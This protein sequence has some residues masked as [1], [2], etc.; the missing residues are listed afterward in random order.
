MPKRE[1]TKP[2]IFSA[3]GLL[4][5]GEEEESDVQLDPKVVVTF[6]AIVGVAI[7]ILYFARPI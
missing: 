1:R 7:L 5:F 4:R 2:A 3:A 6:S